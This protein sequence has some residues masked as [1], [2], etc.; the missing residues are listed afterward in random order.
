MT[1]RRVFAGFGILGA[2]SVALGS[3]LTALAYTGYSP[4]NYFISDLGNVGVSP[5][6]VVFNVS[7]ML[8]GLCMAVFLIGMALRLSGLLRYL[9]GAA[10]LLTG[11]AGTMVGVF[12]MNEVEPHR[13][14]ALTFFM[15]GGIVVALHSLSIGLGKQQTYPRWLAV[16]GLVDVLC[17]AGF[18]SIVV[19]AG[20]AS[21]EF[22]GETRPDFW[23]TTTLEWG[24]LIFLLIWTLSAAYYYSRSEVI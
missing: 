15:T 9:L 17:F 3:L 21:L 20:P 18:L 24:I 5:W 7:L 23:W 19:P 10:G 6:A 13:L 8:G 1:T 22:P 14:A 4:L 2:A 16:I 11:L 12:P